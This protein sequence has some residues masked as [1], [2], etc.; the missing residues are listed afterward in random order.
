MNSYSPILE[1]NP[2][3]LSN[4]TA[5]LAAMPQKIQ[6]LYSYLENLSLTQLPDFEAT[7]QQQ[8]QR[9][10]YLG[11]RDF[12]FALQQSLITPYGYTLS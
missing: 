6:T 11:W 3:F 9:Q 5:P 1:P 12:P 10:T 2:S 8:V 7:N 4:K